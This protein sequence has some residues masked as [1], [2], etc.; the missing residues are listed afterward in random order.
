MLKTHANNLRALIR[1]KEGHH[2]P[3]LKVTVED[4]HDKRSYGSSSRQTR[5]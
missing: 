1:Q 5:S 4:H 2:N 3:D